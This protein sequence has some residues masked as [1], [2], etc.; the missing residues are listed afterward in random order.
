L[1]RAEAREIVEAQ[2]AA[3]AGHWEDVSDEARLT[4]A[5]RTMFARV[6]PHPYALEGFR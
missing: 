3:I 2:L 1:D 5:E 6:F 4:Q